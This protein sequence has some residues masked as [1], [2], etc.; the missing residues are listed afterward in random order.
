MISLLA[1]LVLALAHPA[2]HDTPPELEDLA[3]FQARVESVLEAA[4]PAT[5]GVRVGGTSGSGVLVSSDGLVLTAAHVIGGAG[6]TAR[7]FLADGRELEAETLG[8]NGMRDSGM[9]RIKNVSGLPF[10]SVP[11]PHELEPGSWCVATGHPG[12]YVEDRPPVARLGRIL[13]TSGLFLKTDCP[14]IGGDSGGP[15][16]DLEGNLIGIHSRIEEDVASNYH[17]PMTTYRLG[18]KRMLAGEEWTRSDAKLGV[19]RTVDSATGVWIGEI[20]DGRSAAV[21]GLR[22]SDILRRINGEPVRSLRQLRW[23]LS[24]LRPG[25]E[26][27]VTFLRARET[28][29]CALTLSGPLAPTGDDK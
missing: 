20:L 24:D 18:W 17:V 25:D 3:R 11:A 22:P 23:L 10:V 4:S 8:G 12:G 26:I 2:A 16:F 19:R 27:E 14:V 13:D 15:L 6:R 1:C 5:V 7:V 9:L 28:R 21:A 29:R